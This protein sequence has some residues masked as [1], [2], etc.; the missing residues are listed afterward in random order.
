MHIGVLGISEKTA[1][2]DIREQFSLACKKRLSWES[3]IA[4]RLHIVLLSTCNRT[5]IYFS[6]DNLAEAHSE[7]LQLLREEIDLPFEHKLYSY[8]G[9]DCFFHLALVTAGLD[10]VIL[11]ES[12][13][14]R[15]VKV[16]YEQ[17]ALHYLLPSGMHYLFQKSLKAGKEMRTR[18]SL[19]DVQMS[20]EKLLFQMSNHFFQDLSK[21]SLLFIGN[22]EINRKAIRFFQRKGARQITLCT[23]SPHSAKEMAEKEGITL[24]GWDEL[25]RWQEFPLVICGTSV[26][27]YIVAHPKEGLQ[28][29][30]LFDL[31]LPRSVDPELARHP[32]L[33]LMNMEMLNALLESRQ[34]K[35]S[36]EINRAEEVLLKS[37]H[38]Y[39]EL[40]HQK[41]KRAA[42]CV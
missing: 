16:A 1:A 38:R 40:F 25:S 27:H 5:E 34:E 20:L 33:V 23:R 28:T 36:L 42:L 31:S 2:I 24:L 11:A 26:P 35:N 39:V 19:C 32:Q 22:S 8:F 41:E 6:A 3:E 13:I 29:R 10:S 30:L 9:C 14:Q 37:V 12:E 17:A 15:Q 21:L 7:L 18:F 4:E